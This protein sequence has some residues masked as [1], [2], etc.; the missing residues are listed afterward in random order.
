M[1]FR[2][3]FKIIPK[4]RN[5][6][7]IVYNRIYFSLFGVKY[8]KGLSVNTKIS[9]LGKGRIEIG[10]HFDYS[11]GVNINLIYR[12]FRG[13]IFSKNP[14]SI[15]K[16]G[17]NVKISSACIC[18]N[19]SIQIG[20]NVNVGG[21]CIILDNDSHPHNYIFRRRGSYEQHNNQDAK[22]IVPTSPVVIEDDVWIGA[23][24]VILKGVR[25]GAR[26]IIA[27]GSIV[28]NDIPCDVVA[29]GNPCRVIRNI[30]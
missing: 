14:N 30:K 4:L 7:F 26:T 22:S 6:F 21:E 25:I 29:G 19:E 15:V 23:K 18:A 11:S 2:K 5:S 24:C 17:D 27:A 13:Y 1:L 12:K 3:I 9:L 28:T 10:N 20:N 16:I 8:G